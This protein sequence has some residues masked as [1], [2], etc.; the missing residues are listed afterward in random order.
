MKKKILLTV[1]IGFF[2][3]LAVSAQDIY[4]ED[5]QSVN[6]RIMGMGNGFTAQSSGLRALVTN[7]A[8]IAR[9][10]V[11]HL[12]RKSEVTA[13]S[14]S[15]WTQP[16]PG[17][18]FGA[19]GQFSAGDAAGLSV[20]GTTGARVG[21]DLHGG[22]LTQKPWGSLAFSLS[23]ITD[24]ESN[25]E[26]SLDFL[27]G[28]G[29][30]K[31]QFAIGYAYEFELSGI[32]LR[33]GASARPLFQTHNS[34]TRRGVFTSYI[35]SGNDPFVI[36]NSLEGLHGFSVAHDVGVQL[37]WAGFTIGAD[38]HNAYAPI[39]YT[40]GAFS[41]YITTFAGSTPSDSYRF[42]LTMN[43]A[44]AYN[45]EIQ[46]IDWLEQYFDFTL[47]FQ[48]TDPFYLSVQPGDTNPNFLTRINTGIEFE[49]VKPFIK[50]QAGINK[51]GPTFGMGFDVWWFDL[52]FALYTEEEGDIRE[53]TTPGF[54]A[55]LA[56]RW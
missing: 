25:T 40:Q 38:L 41:D 56:F 21:L 36:L 54:V 8:G 2:T 52:S 1:L 30:S 9:S 32:L 13:F 7:P 49:I 22:Y 24:V 42:P 26:G 37:E 6:P 31:L 16:Y 55:E 29:V 53:R 10:F 4:H 45:L 5:I 28:T 48:L 43:I 46:A 27:V 11:S 34:L 50:V 15:L 19:L 47:Y 12:E 51:G 39:F 14:I 3:T 17:E 18:L 44:I 33:L 35:E 23:S 20:F